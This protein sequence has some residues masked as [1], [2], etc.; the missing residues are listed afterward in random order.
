[1]KITMQG[2]LYA[3]LAYSKDR[4]NT[5]SVPTGDLCQSFADGL[6]AKNND[7]SNC[8]G[9]K[10]QL[11]TA[12]QKRKADRAARCTTENCHQP[13]DAVQ[14]VAELIDDALAH[15]SLPGQLEAALAPYCHHKDTIH[16]TLTPSTAQAA[17]EPKLKPL[18]MKS[19]YDGG[20]YGDKDGVFAGFALTL[21]GQTTISSLK[22]PLKVESTGQCTWMA[23][24]TAEADQKKY[25]PVVAVR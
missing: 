7:F 8:Q 25:I 22:H 1:M 24:T 14:S 18:A 20:Y 17:S 13:G 23:G 3:S 9:L 12:I 15:S 2:G 4:G 11:D 19:D 10:A 5:I 21:M 16:P 6:N